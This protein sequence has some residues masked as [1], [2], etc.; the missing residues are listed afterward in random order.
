VHNDTT[1]DHAGSTLLHALRQL[2]GW[3]A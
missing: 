2:P 3:P 1:L